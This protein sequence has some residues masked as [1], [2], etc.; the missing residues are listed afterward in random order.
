MKISVIITSYNR[1]KDLKDAIKSVIQQTHQA[2]ELIVVDDGSLDD[3]VA[4][5]NRLTADLPWAKVI[6]QQNQGQTGAVITGIKH[7][8]GDAI[9]FLDGDDMWTPEHLKYASE[10][11]ELDPHI[12]LYYS[13]IEAFGSTRKVPCN[14][15]KGDGLMGETFFLT[16]ATK[17]FIGNINASMVARRSSLQGMVD[18]PPDLIEDWRICT[19]NV[20]GWVSSLSGMTKFESHQKT[21]LHRIHEENNHHTFKQKPVKQAFRRR[22]YRIFHYFASYYHFGQVSSSEIYK[23]FKSHTTPSESI[24]K[25]YSKACMS[26]CINES[27]AKKLY[28]HLRIKVS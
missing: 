24:K 21:M 17:T 26:K 1:A 16:A 19:D 5:A 18:L 10:A 28:Y 13:N 3:S 27:I 9:A 25:I 8:T 15:L 6:A 7:S 12:G 20:I 22:F 2:H 23:E 14:N 4:V 11:L